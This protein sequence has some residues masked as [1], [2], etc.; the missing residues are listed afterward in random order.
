VTQTNERLA[1]EGLGFVKPLSRFY[2]K[3]AIFSIPLSGR[4][5]M[6]DFNALELPIK[7]AEI[8]G[9]AFRALQDRKEVND[10]PKANVAEFKKTYAAVKDS[11]MSGL[12]V[13]SSEKF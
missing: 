7:R 13:L 2:R 11:L 3:D 1:Y 9:P 8:D 5:A 12:K 10:A 4:H 6:I